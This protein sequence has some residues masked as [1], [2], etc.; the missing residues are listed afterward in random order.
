MTANSILGHKCL[1]ENNNIRRKQFGTDTGMRG[2]MWACWDLHKGRQRTLR[3]GGH[4]VK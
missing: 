3:Q 2:K 1:M 4:C